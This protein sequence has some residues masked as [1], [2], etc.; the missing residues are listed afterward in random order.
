M[1]NVALRIWIFLKL[2]F[3][4]ITKWPSLNTKPVN[5]LSHPW[6]IHVKKMW[7]QKIFGFVWTGAINWYLKDLVTVPLICWLRSALIYL[8]Q[9]EI[10]H[11][12]SRNLLV[13]ATYNLTRST[14][15]DK[16]SFNT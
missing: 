11:L 1:S 10:S 3:C 4:F 14:Y 13:T 8:Q 7:F 15:Q 16:C 5:P 2:N 9:K 6:P 12:Q